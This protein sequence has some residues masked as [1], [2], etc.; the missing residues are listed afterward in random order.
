MTTRPGGVGLPNCLA[1]S[2]LVLGAVDAVEVGVS[3][4]CVLARSEKGPG[5]EAPGPIARQA[6]GSLEG[7]LVALL[8][9]G[10]EVILGGGLRRERA[11]TPR[12]ARG[13]VSD[14]VGL[15]TAVSS[16]Q[17]LITSPKS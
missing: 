7:D 13:G 16:S 6:I 11:I 8:H 2:A 14:V 10:V 12:R 3:H 17:V 9:V 1:G 5:A 4:R 15:G